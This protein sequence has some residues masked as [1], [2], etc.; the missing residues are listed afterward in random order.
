MDRGGVSTHAS[1]VKTWEDFHI[2]IPSGAK[3]ECDTTCPQ[4][5]HARKKKQAKCLSV[6]LTKGTWL[7]H[8]CSWRGGLQGGV[9]GQS[10]P[11]T[12]KPKV[13]SKPTYPIGLE[14][15]EQVMTWFAKRGISQSTIETAQVCG[16]CVY[17][18]Q[19]EEYEN[20][21]QFPYFRDG[22]LI[23][24]KY[25]TMEGK[26]FRMVGGA[27]RIFYGLDGLKDDDGKTVVICEGEVDWLSFLEIGWVSVV[28]VPDGAI[29]PGSQ[30]VSEKMSYLDS[31][32]PWLDPMQRIILATDH[33]EA[34]LALRS[35]LIRRLGVE[36]CESVT[37]PEGCKD[38]NDVLLQ[39]GVEGVRQLLDQAQPV[40]ISRI[41]RPTV[42]FLLPNP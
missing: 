2:T 30:A 18:P 9:E 3:E 14:L 5:S 31:A 25:R 37:Y 33:D 11:W 13:Y 38:A 10:N 23:N 4:C 32:Q 28:S 36:R 1:P 27:E 12:W 35:E 15:S 16:G 22:E 34:G 8:H 19:T 17:M 21:I 41:V 7:C 26:D 40:L 20:V 42:P 29:T 6:N 39:F 24:V